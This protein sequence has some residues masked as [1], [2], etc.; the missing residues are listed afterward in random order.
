MKTVRVFYT[1]SLGLAVLCSSCNDFLDK[2]PLSQIT[3]E[4]YLLTESDL[5]SYVNGLYT[6]ILPSHNTVWSYGMFGWDAHTDNQ[7]AWNYS[8]KFVPGQYK[9]PHSEDSEW[10]FTN[11]YSCNYFLS[12]TV[13]LLESG[14]LSGN[15][16][17]VKYY[18]GEAYF[19]RAY[20][21]FT[22]YQKFGDFPIV[23]VPLKDEQDLLVEASKRAPRNE[24]ARF[25][26][27]D[28][29]KAIELMGALKKPT[30]RISADLARLVKS[31]VALFEGTWLKYFKGTAF[32]PDGENWP[33]SKKNAG[34]SYAYPSGSIDNEIAYFLNIAMEA[35]KEVGDKYIGS[36]TDNTGTVQQSLSEQENP[37]MMMFADL[38]LSKYPEV[39]LWREYNKGL[40]VV[41]NVPVYCQMGNRGVGVTRGLVSSFVMQNGLPVY[42]TGSMYHGD[43]TIAD[44]RKDR[45]S[46]LSIF[47]KEPGQKNILI[48]DPSGTT[49]QVEE[50]YPNITEGSEERTYNTGYALRKGWSYDQGQ[51]VNGFGYTAC[52]SFRAAEALL[53]YMEASYELQSRVDETARS[54]WKAL[55]ERSKVDADYE[56]TI[57]NTDMSQEVL[58]DWGA[59]SAGKIIDPVLY[60]IRR[61]R[62]SELMAEGLRFMD[63]IRWRAMDQMITTPYHIEGFHLYNTPMEEWYGGKLTNDGSDKANASSPERSEYLRPYEKNSKS[64]VYDGYRWAMAHYLS[65][66]MIK[67]FQLTSTDGSNLESSPMYQNPGWPMTAD[68]GAEF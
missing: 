21:Y 16:E 61:E 24:V 11:I 38:D 43:R 45:D 5:E 46:R 30:T 40:G 53:N 27:G 34:A 59:Y 15:L 13:P 36:L 42:A 10:K 20:E 65:P 62:R 6:G 51:C 52:A 55:R 4:H 14:G 50:P 44:V 23:T 1:I 25:I 56:K 18:I 26:I 58:Y 68:E 32:V 19:L 66:I 8:N 49:Y 22:R 54:Y 57:A 31:R 7:A 12:R 48:F 64:E 41:H 3:P 60:N 33:G 67:Q 35:A 9:V 63:L 2:T 28:L 37:Y 39:L 29:D 47:L 17:N